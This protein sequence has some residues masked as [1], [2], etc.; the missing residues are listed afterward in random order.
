MRDERACGRRAQSHCARPRRERSGAY[1]H[2]SVPTA[3]GSIALG[4]AS[5]RSSSASNHAATGRRREAQ[6]Q[7]RAPKG[8]SRWK[9]SK[10]STRTGPVDV[11]GDAMTRRTNGDVVACLG[12]RRSLL[13]PFFFFFLNLHLYSAT[14]TRG[15]RRGEHSV[16]IQL[17]GHRV[18]P[19]PCVRTLAVNHALRP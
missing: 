17:K 8:E 1:T 16:H 5:M 9:E 6:L 11:S 19:F 10:R 3:T 14:A 7:R 12:A 18:E 15:A 4:N 13:S 2:T